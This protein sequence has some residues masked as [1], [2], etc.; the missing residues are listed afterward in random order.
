[1]GIQANLKP[2]IAIG[3]V[4]GDGFNDL[5]LGS[6]LASNSASNSGSAWV[7]FSSLLDDFGTTTGNVKLLATG[8][9]Y[10]IRYDG[11]NASDGLT[12]GGRAIAI[13]D[14]NSDGVS[15]LVLGAYEADYGGGSS[16]SAY[17]MFSTLIDDVG[18]TTG[19]NKP[20]STGTNYNIRYDGQTND[21]FSIGGIFIGDINGDDMGDMVVDSYDI[22]VMFSTLIDDVGTTTG[23][24]K[25]ISVS[26]NY[27]IIYS[28]GGSS[29]LT[30]DI[31]GDGLGDFV[32]GS[33]GADNNGTWSGSVW[34]LFST[35]IDDVGTTTGNSKSLNNASNF[36]IRYDGSVPYE[37]ISRYGDVVTHDLDLDGHLDLVIG[38]NNAAY[39]L[40]STLIDD[41]GESTGNIK[42]FSTSTN[43]SIR[44][45]GPSGSNMTS[46]NAMGAGDV[47]NDGLP[48]LV[49]GDQY[50]SNNGADSGSV[51]VIYGTPPPRYQ[52]EGFIEISGAVSFE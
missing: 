3:D 25:P 52:T 35:L 42:P 14:I 51:W 7:I 49:F 23:N 33:G 2:N 28:D 1:M 37:H 38:S 9:N 46:E 40:Y 11:A 50:S 34:L 27:N 18:T 17:V 32:T 15:D 6:E 45:G 8:T 12:R 22:V 47:N 41:V 10:N 21:W 48:D 4:N 36:N 30:G 20:L 29:Y 39:V 31:N 16:G 19:N 43:Y 13:G 44:Y 26:T 24:N 5:V